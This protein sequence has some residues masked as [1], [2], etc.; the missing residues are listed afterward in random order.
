[1]N[2]LKFWG[3]LQANLKPGATIKNWTAAKGYLGDE[4]KILAVS[5]N[6]VEVDSPKA[7]NLQ[8]VSKSDFEVTYNK[9]D[10]YCSGKLQR[11]ELKDTTRFSK[12][13]ISIIK[14]IEGLLT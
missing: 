4:F 7:E 10:A 2:F 13:T 9:W 1:M 8:Y 12:Y 11:Q 5:A 6:G 14:H 3:G